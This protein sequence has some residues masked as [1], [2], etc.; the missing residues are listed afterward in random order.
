VPFDP[1]KPVDAAFKQ[2]GIAAIL[3]PE[4]EARPVT[5]IPMIG[6]TDAGFDGLDIRKPG[7]VLRIRSR[8]MAGFGEG[9]ILD[10]KDVRKKVKSAP[11]PQ[12]S[13]GYVFELDVQNVG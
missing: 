10:V 8:E 9:A 5:V 12:D 1:S 11:V 3:D 7:I 13:L 4:G 2:F 6:D